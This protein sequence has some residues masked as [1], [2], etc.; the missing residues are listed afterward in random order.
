[1]KI[2]SVLFITEAWEMFKEEK[3]QSFL[4]C[5][6]YKLSILINWFFVAQVWAI[7]P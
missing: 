7:L 5:L 3:T 1:M 6:E 2:I 4:P